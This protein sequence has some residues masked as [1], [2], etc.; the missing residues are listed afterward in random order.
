MVKG[1]YALIDCTGLDLAELGKVTGLYG[2]LDAAIKSGKFILLANVV[3]GDASFSP[4]PSFG[5]YDNDGIFVSFEPVTIHVTSGD[6]V[7]I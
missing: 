4:I 7:T 2:Q 5:G 6:V 3:N 1:G